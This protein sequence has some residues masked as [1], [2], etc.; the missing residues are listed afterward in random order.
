MGAI[1]NSA[2]STRWFGDRSQ[3]EEGW[4]RRISLQAEGMLG[5]GSKEKKA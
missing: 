5:R 2:N 4:E 1:E 3:R